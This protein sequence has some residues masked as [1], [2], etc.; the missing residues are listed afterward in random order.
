[1]YTLFSFPVRYL[2]PFNEDSLSYTGLLNITEGSLFVNGNFSDA[3]VNITGGALLGGDGRVGPVT[4]YTG[5]IAPGNSPGIIS[6]SGDLAL[7][8]ADT[9]FFEINGT[10]PGPSMIKLKSVEMYI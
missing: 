9:L 3:P 8:A 1:M 10:T 5:D 4:A 6:V 7:G 2:K